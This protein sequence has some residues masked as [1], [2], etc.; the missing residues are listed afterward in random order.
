MAAPVSVE[1]ALKARLIAD[2]TVNNYVAGRIFPVAIP[3]GVKDYPCITYRRT[4]TDREQQSR[5]ATGVVG[6]RIELRIWSKDYEENKLVFDAVRKELD[7]LQNQVVAG[8]APNTTTF[9]IRRVTIEPPGEHDD[10]EESP[11]SDG[12]VAFALVV[13]LRIT[14]TETTAANIGA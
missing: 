4:G 14:H 12:S 13:P 1:A 8:T 10:P 3:T 11:Y 2:T 7:G 9:S 6:A 5:G